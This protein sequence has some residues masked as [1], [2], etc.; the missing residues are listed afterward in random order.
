MDSLTDKLQQV[1]EFDLFVACLRGEAEGEPFSGKLAIACV[2]R[3]RVNDK[4]WPDSYRGVML[5]PFQF[6]C[7]LPKYFRTETLNHDWNRNY[8]RECRYAAWGVYYGWIWDITGG[9][10]H[11]HAIG[12]HPSWAEDML[13][14]NIGW[15][16]GH[17]IFYVG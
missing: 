9:A 2:I 14:A 7:F 11:Y 17:H 1:E 3:N 12:V 15:S 4:R 16:T 5:Q 8:Y 13:I 10:N 6:S